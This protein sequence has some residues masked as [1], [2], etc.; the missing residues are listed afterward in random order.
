MWSGGRGHGQRAGLVIALGLG[1]AHCTEQPTERAQTGL[2]ALSLEALNPEI[3]VPGS[4]IELLGR[5]F[6][7]RPLGVSWLH[8]SGTY[9]G[10]PLDTYLPAEFIDFTQMEI[11]ATPD[12]LRLLGPPQGVFNGTVQIEVDFVSDGSRHASIPRAMELQIHQTLEPRIDDVL[13]SGQIYVNE[14]LEVTGSG[15]L[16]GGDEGTTYAV[17]QGCFA[18]TDG[19]GTCQPVAAVEVPV[20]PVTPF[21][22]EHGVFGFSPR[23]AGIEAGH[24]S[25]TVQLRNDHADGQAFAS[26][27]VAVEYDLAEAFVAWAGDPSGDAVGSLGRY[28]EVEG[29]GFIDDDDGLTTLVLMGEY[30]PD[31]GPGGPVELEVIPQFVDGRR[32]RYVINEQDG[33]AQLVDVRA[34]RGLFAGQ[35]WPRVEFGSQQVQG[36]P[37]PVS[38]RLEPVKQ[39]VYLD[40]NTTYVESLRLFG[41]RALDAQLRARIL[42]VLER[43][44]E[45]INVEF[46]SEPPTD[47][48]LFATIEVAGPDPN[49]LGLL[50]YDNTVGKD[51]NNLRLDD[52]I[53]GINAQTLDQGLPGFG[54]V[55]M[56]SLFSFSMHPP[57]GTVPSAEVAT[58]LFDE[59][60]DPLRPDRGRPVTSTDI[61]I[62]VPTFTGGAPC[63]AADRPSQIACAVF[64]LG[65]VVGSTVS[66]ELGH[67]V[68]LAD[69]YGETFHNAGDL[70]NRLMDP[71]G[72]RSFEERAELMGQGPSRFCV[73]SYEY[74]RLILPTTELDPP[75][76]RPPC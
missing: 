28:I 39:V 15:L 55:F 76:N 35:M 34:A 63:P 47:Y 26:D 24:F 75:V 46:R 16:L 52:H 31:D 30:L 25:G 14:P 56:E 3:I 29:G 13:A 53:G 61:A 9:A 50:G 44:W 4:R 54:G 7:G 70:P 66:H 74:L 38:I 10:A 6:L 59:V 5:S 11:V 48:A 72:A 65:S 51:S 18:S 71:G 73:G 21:D 42:D 60:F 40:Y 49:G 22:R 33:L 2:E 58:T 17:V 69:P 67:S 41:V 62:G 43:D 19:D 20:Q 36:P 23:I 45:A 68:G 64:V 57:A 27:S 8:L 37:T 1:S 32:V 12:I